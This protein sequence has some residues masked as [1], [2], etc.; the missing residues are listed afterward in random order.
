[1]PYQTSSARPPPVLLRTQPGP[2]I[3]GADQSP[4]ALILDS[5][6]LELPRQTFLSSTNCPVSDTLSPQDEWMKG[7][8]QVASFPSQTQSK[9][10]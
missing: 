10:Q 9:W 8:T 4:R 1:M 7:D 6:P 5:Q 2:P 3:L